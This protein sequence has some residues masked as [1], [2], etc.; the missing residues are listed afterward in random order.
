MI[1]GTSA[2]E[3]FNFYAREL[4]LG[5]NYI[6]WLKYMYPGNGS[7]LFLRPFFIIYDRKITVR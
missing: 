1:K 6:C 7:H 4:K 3:V 2:L 5:V